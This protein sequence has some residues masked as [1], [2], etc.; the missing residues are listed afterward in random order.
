MMMSMRRVLS[1]L[2][3][4]WVCA[5]AFLA[6]GSASAAPS[7]TPPPYPPV[8]PP[9][10]SVSTTSPCVGETIDVGGTGFT[11]GETVAL[12]VGGKAAGS[13]TVGAAG[14]FTATVNT[15]GVTGQQEL[16]VVGQS[17]GL[18]ATASL[19]VSNCSGVSGESSSR[20]LAF[21]GVQI[22]GLCVAGLVLIG[23]GVLFVAAG[24]RRNAA[25]GA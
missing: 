14:S 7:P 6:A 19:T 16:G 12:N 2:A 8:T 18:V 20:G 24:R 11:G 23:G 4:L 21:T 5:A 9:S 3:V 1:A 15:P 22:A 17:S 25:L 13:A 10:V